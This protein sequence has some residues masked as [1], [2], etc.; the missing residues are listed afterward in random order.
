M[1]TP[2][3]IAKSYILSAFKQATQGSISQPLTNVKIYTCDDEC[4]SLKA[5]EIH[6][7]FAKELALECLD[8]IKNSEEN[9]WGDELETEV[10]T[11]KTGDFVYSLLLGYPA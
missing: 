7:Y 4:Y 11:N 5:F 8:E 9:V 6:G 10:I 1:K 3:E 2:K